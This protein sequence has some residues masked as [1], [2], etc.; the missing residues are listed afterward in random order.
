M[1]KFINSPT[2]IIESEYDS[3]SMD[4]ILNEECYKGSACIDN[5]T[6]T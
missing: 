3:W 1:V 4:N 5:C 2:F 6:S